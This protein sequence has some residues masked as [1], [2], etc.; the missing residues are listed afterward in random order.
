[1]FSTRSESDARGID[2]LPAVRVR[3]RL[4]AGGVLKNKE[5]WSLELG[6]RSL[7]IREDLFIDCGGFRIVEE[8]TGA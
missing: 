1:L 3:D 4:D 8:L 7:R 2:E 6:A 5:A